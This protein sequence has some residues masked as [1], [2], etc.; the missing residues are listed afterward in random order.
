[1]KEYTFKE[2]SW[3][4]RVAN[5]GVRRIYPRYGTDICE[6]IQAFIAG[7][8]VA[9]MS[10][11]FVC[12]MIMWTGAAVYDIVQSILH[13]GKLTYPAFMFVFLVGGLAVTLGLIAGII[14]LRDRYQNMPKSELAEPGFVKLAYRKFKHKTCVKIKFEGV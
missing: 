11:V 8:F 7:A 13:G 4:M 9:L 14:Y 3:H 12:L 1:M 2:N 6:Y 5:F 10:F